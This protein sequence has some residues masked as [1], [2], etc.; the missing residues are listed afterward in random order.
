MG[1]S[2]S[3]PVA[4][5]AKHATRTFPS[6]PPPAAIRSA[7]VPPRGATPS[8]EGQQRQRRPDGAA[9]AST[10]PPPRA[11]STKDDAIRA[12]GMDPQSSSSSN[13][14][15]DHRD[16]DPDHHT[17]AAFSARLRQ[18]GVATPN[19]TLSNSS[20]VNSANPAATT[21]SSSSSSVQDPSLSRQA[22]SPT[23]SSR[24]P[25]ISSLGG[26]DLNSTASAKTL[27]IRS[28]PGG[29]AGGQASTTLNAL[30]VRKELAARAAAQFERGGN[31]DREFLDVNTLRQI[32]QLV[33][34]GAAS[35]AE[36]EQRLKLKK[37]VVARLVGGKAKGVFAPLE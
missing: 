7:P 3:K 36:I 25:S 26:R 4:R 15:Q 17:N 13:P 37:G 33:H 24:N 23:T 16:I 31:T 9:S 1:G 19:P 27:P 21:T 28:Q 6:R 22:P 8:A 20:I 12:D 34:S 2:A 14:F 10:P 35:E 11:S 29:A 18:M 30:Q 5:T 32:L